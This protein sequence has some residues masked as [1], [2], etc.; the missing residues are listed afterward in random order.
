MEGAFDSGALGVGPDVPA[1]DFSEDG[2]D[3]RTMTGSDFIP[4]QNA[5]RLKR[6]NHVNSAFKGDQDVVVEPEGRYRRNFVRKRSRQQLRPAEIPRAFFYFLEKFSPPQTG[7]FFE[8]QKEEHF[9]F[10]KNSP[11]ETGTSFC[12]K[13]SLNI[14]K[15][16]EK[17]FE[18]PTSTHDLSYEKIRLAD[19]HKIPIF[20]DK[21]ENPHARV[22]GVHK[23]LTL[24]PPLVLVD[25][26]GADHQEM[27]PL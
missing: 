23:F 19:C 15:M 21:S 13:K 2:P 5:S 25:N 22:T 9:H 10:S 26:H 7:E 18:L 8:S 27:K 11:G 24:M 3:F 12:L 17:R 20:S 4:V 14:A 16:V 6:K 1:M